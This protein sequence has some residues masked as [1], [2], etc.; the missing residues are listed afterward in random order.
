MHQGLTNKKNEHS[1]LLCPRKINAISK[2]TNVDS[3]ENST[4]KT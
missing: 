4:I 1:N 2:E 3:T